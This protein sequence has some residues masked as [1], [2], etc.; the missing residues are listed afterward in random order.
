M[1]TPIVAPPPA[2]LPTTYYPKPLYAADLFGEHRARQLGFTEGFLQAAAAHRGD[3]L[4]GYRSGYRAGKGAGQALGE[5]SAEHAK[6]ERLLKV[7]VVGLGGLFLVKGIV[8][9]MQKWECP[10]GYV[11]DKRARRCRR[12]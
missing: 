12:A 8:G 9:R 5:M 11:P 1:W 6:S 10:S 7:A 3:F 4:R 2:P